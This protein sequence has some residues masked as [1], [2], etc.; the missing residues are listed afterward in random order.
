MNEL[1]VTNERKVST[2]SQ[3]VDSGQPQRD[4]K[5]SAKRAKY[6]GMYLPW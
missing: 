1:K 5:G 2:I 6:S 4:S 3:R